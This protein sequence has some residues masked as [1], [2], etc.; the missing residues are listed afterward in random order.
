MRT[1]TEIQRIGKWIYILLAVDFLVV[2][3]I[4]NK[5]Y[6][7]EKTS[8][9]E[10]VTIVIV[11]IIVTAFVIALVSLTGQYTKIDSFGVHFKYPPIQWRWKTLP[12]QS[13]QRLEISNN[14]SLRTGYAY[15]KWNIFKEDPYITTMGYEK[16]IRIY[17]KDG[18]T[19]CIGTR[20]PSEF[21]ETLKHL[22][23]AENVTY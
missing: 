20:K 3:L 5:E 10:F 6:K 7:S 4:L 21:Y 23:S 8:G 2:F 15:G 11:M 13:I 12:L 19:L 22:K 1:F 14:F 17:F 9:E 18:K 16:T